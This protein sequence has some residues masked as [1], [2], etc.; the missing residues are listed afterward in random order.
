MLQ[1]VEYEYAMP[2][3]AN[4]GRGE[5]GLCCQIDV[6]EPKYLKPPIFSDLVKPTNS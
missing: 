2:C 3:H 6:S 1:L 4:Y 5:P